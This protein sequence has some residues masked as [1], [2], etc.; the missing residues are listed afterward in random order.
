MVEEWKP[1][2]HIYGLPNCHLMKDLEYE[3]RQIIKSNDRHG[4]NLSVRVRA[5]GLRRDL[6][7]AFRALASNEIDVADYYRQETFLFF[8]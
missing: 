3:S 5:S 6:A 2:V 8:F 7:G 1:L 4:K